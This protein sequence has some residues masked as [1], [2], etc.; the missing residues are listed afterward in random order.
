VSQAPQRSAQA[1]TLCSPRKQV[2]SCACRRLTARKT[3]QQPA[4][5]GCRPR[6]GGAGGVG[7]QAA[8]VLRWLRIPGEEEDTAPLKQVHP[9]FAGL[10]YNCLEHHALLRSGKLRGQDDDVSLTNLKLRSQTL[11]K[12]GKIPKGKGTILVHFPDEAEQEQQVPSYNM[13]NAIA[14]GGE[15]MVSVLLEKGFDSHE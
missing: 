6:G 1:L 13:T 15:R 3:A 5:S 11:K 2:K 7:L 8:Q 12:S 10:Q 4:G 14:A 9:L